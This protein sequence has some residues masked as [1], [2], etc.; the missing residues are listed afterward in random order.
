MAPVRRVI[1]QGK[2][3]GGRRLGSRYGERIVSELHAGFSLFLFAIASAIV[4][5][6]L[7][8][9][10]VRYQS[11][12]GWLISMQTVIVLVLIGLAVRQRD[13]IHPPNKFAKSVNYNVFR[14]QCLTCR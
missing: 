8:G 7:V 11:P 13:R 14:V 2:S 12:V 5:Y 1:E 10:H 6:T 9:D 3:A 4:M